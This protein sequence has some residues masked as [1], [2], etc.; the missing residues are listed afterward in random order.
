MKPAANCHC[1][2]GAGRD[3]RGVTLVE[4]LVMI[5]VLGL[6]AA[7]ALPAVQHIREGARRTACQNNLRQVALAV[8]AYEGVHKALPTGNTDYLGTRIPSR[9]WLQA[10][11]PHIERQDVLDRAQLDYKEGLTV[12]KHAGLSTVIELYQCPSEPNTG[13]PNRTHGDWMVASTSYLGVIGPNWKTTSG[14]LFHNSSVQIGQI[15]DGLSNTLLAGERPPSPDFWYGWWYCGYGQQGTGSCDMLLGTH[16]IWDQATPFIM[17]PPE[18]PV[19]YQ[20]GKP[21]RAWDTLHYW[22]YHPGGANFAWCDGSVRL[23][24]YAAD[25]VIDALGTRDG[26]EPPPGLD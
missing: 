18:G 3:R 14:V 16:E 2:T 19:P 12:P 11:L 21:G 22:S 7:I 1:R 6:L 20:P 5:G 15:T 25:S 26:A 24:S 10:I 8:L 17:N 9:S 4:C 23:L 13:H